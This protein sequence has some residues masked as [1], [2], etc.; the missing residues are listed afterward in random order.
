M[1]STNGE[2]EIYGYLNMADGHLAIIS[3]NKSLYELGHQMRPL[4]NKLRDIGVSYMEIL[5][6]LQFSQSLNALLE[7]KFLPSAIYPAMY[8]IDGVTTDLVVMTRTLEPLNFT[9]IQ[10]EAGFKPY[11]DV[12]VKLWK[13]MYLE[14]LEVFDD[15]KS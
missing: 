11:V 2:V 15:F 3:L 1:A 12:Y 7:A 8:E 9:G 14:T 13:M 10:I 4:L 6:G 5:I